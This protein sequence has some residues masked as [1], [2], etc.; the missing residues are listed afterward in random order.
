MNE[1]QVDFSIVIPVYNNEGSLKLIFQAI[2]EKVIKKN[3]D[4]SCD[5]IFVD[6]GSGDN[7]FNEIMEIR[8]ENPSLVKVIKFVRNFGQLQAIIAG[9]KISRGKCVISIS[10][11]LHDPP[12][13]INDML[14][15]HFNEGYPIVV[16]SRESRDESFFR[17][18]TSQIFYSLM[19]KLSFPYMPIKEFDYILLSETVKNIIL[20]KQETN[21]FFQGQVLWTGYNIKFIPY[22]REK[23]AFGK[24]SWTF[25][26]KLKYLIDGVLSYSY[27]PLRAMS[28]TGLIVALLGFLYAFIILIGRIVGS[29]PIQGWA[30]LMIIFLVLSGIQMLM[31]GIIGEYLWRALDQVRNRQP[32]STEKIF[33]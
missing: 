8:N 3:P 31:V 29:V 21:A 24:S 12:E 15:Y 30:P 4:R 32:Y 18:S 16:C 17:R 19:K 14:N 6:D 13:M 1:K 27:F 5:I 2:D 33:D 22:K 10:A 28:V 26:K 11:D 7:S 9:Y 25:S 20:E 23:R